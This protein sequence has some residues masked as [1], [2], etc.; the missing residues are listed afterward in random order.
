MRLD[1][2]FMNS[3]HILAGPKVQ[4][5]NP[6]FLFLW[7]FIKLSV[8]DLCDINNYIIPLFTLPYSTHLHSTLLKW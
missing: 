7:I 6:E 3:V 5:S 4:L 1:L 2:R 8:N